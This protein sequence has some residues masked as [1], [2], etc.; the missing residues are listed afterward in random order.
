MNL[1]LKHINEIQTRN[2]LILRVT[3]YTTIS[4]SQNYP[5]LTYTPYKVTGRA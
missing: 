4:L 5:K 1:G 2:L 3:P